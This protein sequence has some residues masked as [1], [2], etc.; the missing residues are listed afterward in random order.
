MAKKF[1][2]NES[3]KI[4][5]W[6]RFTQFWIVVDLVISLL[7][8]IDWRLVEIF[9]LLVCFVNKPMKKY[10][11][12]KTR[13]TYIWSSIDWPVYCKESKVETINGNFQFYTKICISKSKI[14]FGRKEKNVTC[15]CRE[16]RK[17]DIIGF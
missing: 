14:K 16:F 3:Y 1:F 12:S 11:V 9:L 8:G 15:L 10:K 17:L 7:A 6:L 13:K 2:L 5:S 4:F